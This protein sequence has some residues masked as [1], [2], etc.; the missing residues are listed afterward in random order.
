MFAYVCC[1]HDFHV[2]IL[3]IFEICVSSRLRTKFPD[4]RL[5]S[6]CAGSATASPARSQKR[7]RDNEKQRN[8]KKNKNMKKKNEKIEITIEYTVE[9]N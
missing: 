1:F 6:R 5:V 7:R 9:Y 3:V 4:P 8:T 2:A